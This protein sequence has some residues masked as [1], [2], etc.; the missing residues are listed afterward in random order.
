MRRWMFMAALSAALLAIP[1]WGQRGGRGGIVMGGPRGGFVG[2]PRG[3]YWGGGV[4]TVHGPGVYGFHGHYPYYPGRY[5]YFRCR[6]P[7]WGYRSYYYGYPSAL[8][9]YGGVGVGW[10]DA[11]YSDP[12]ESYPASAYAPPETSS[13]YIAS[14]QQH[15]IDQ[16]KDELARL[17]AERVSANPAPEPSA[18]E[19]RDDTVLV[20]R[21]HRVEQIQNYAIVGDTLWVLTQQRARKVSVVELDI[22]ATAKANEDLGIDFRLPTR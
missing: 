13:A 18:A 19:V 2:A 16:L 12:A 9:W 10:S 17:R 6:Y 7:W 1:V 14:E 8:G 4:H 15:E 22:P 21:D 5:P 11:S 3:A 20:F